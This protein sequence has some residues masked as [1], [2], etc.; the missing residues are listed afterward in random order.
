M[1]GVLPLSAA[2]PTWVKTPEN[3]ADLKASTAK[4]KGENKLSVGETIYLTFTNPSLWLLG[5]ALGM[6]NGD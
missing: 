4:A 5:I 2:I 1:A 3:V 6:L